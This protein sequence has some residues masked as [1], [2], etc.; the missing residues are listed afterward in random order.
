MQVSQQ[1]DSSPAFVAVVG[2]LAAYRHNL[3]FGQKQ[4]REYITMNC[5]ISREEK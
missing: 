4:R 5:K 2:V 1:Y 3:N